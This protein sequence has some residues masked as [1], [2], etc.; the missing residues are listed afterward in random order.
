[1]INIFNRR[2]LFTDNSAEQSAK[3]WSRLKEHGIPYEMKTMRNHTTF[4]RNIHASMSMQ[5][6]AG[7]MG[8]DPFS[9]NMAYTYVIYVKNR[10]YNRARALIA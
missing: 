6:G 5:V 3:V 4:G 2:K 10:D 1:M 8:Y 7:G 9:D